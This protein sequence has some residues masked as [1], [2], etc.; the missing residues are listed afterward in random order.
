MGTGPVIK[1]K[2]RKLDARSKAHGLYEYQVQFWNTKNYI[3]IRNWCWD[4]WGSSC[5]YE[6][7]RKTY[8]ADITNF[9]ESWCFQTEP[10][11]PKYCI[12]IKDEAALMLFK[13]R[14]TGPQ[15]GKKTY[16]F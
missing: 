15:D 9:N 14:W 1:Y 16:N 2:I 6:L 12:Y 13:L 4:N 10:E 7:L 8:G 5:E 11:I 3:E